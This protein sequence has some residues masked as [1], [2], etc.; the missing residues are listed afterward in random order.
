M[1]DRRDLA[2][3]HADFVMALAAHKPCPIALDPNPEDFTARA[4]CCETLIARMHTHLTALIADA[5]ENEPGRA[6]RDAELLASIDA[7]LGDLKSDITG[8]LEQIA[9][10][11]REARYDGCARGPF[12]RRRA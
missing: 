11:I 8:T 10:R 12:Y 6:I 2:K 1:T 4:I 3:V 7:H 5:A 9:E